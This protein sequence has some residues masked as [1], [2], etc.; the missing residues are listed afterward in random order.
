MQNQGP[1]SPFPPGMN[2]PFDP[3]QMDKMKR[4]L[5]RR[6]GLF[7]LGAVIVIVGAMID[8]KQSGWP[9]YSPTL[10]ML[11]GG[12]VGFMGLLG[13]SRGAG[14]MAQIAAFFWLMGI[15]CNVGATS[16]WSQYALAGGALCFVVLA[17]LLPKKAPP[18]GMSA[19]GQPGAGG[20]NPFAGFPGF[21]APRPGS[22]LPTKSGQKGQRPR[23]IDVDAHE[24][25]ADTKRD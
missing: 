1:Q 13:M 21:G 8:P 23:V 6:F 3:S 20:M 25:K 19:P 14:C 17:L 5:K 11:V 2:L 22:T 12:A 10:V 16:T 4:E 7:A 18:F 24:T 15:A 9:L